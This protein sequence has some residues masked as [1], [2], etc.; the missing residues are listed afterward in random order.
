MLNIL[1]G[2]IIGRFILKI[3]LKL[4]ISTVIATYLNSSLSR[5][6]IKR[7][8]KK[9]D[10][11]MS[12]FPNEK[13]RSFGEFFAR[14]KSSFTFDEEKHHFI[15]PCDGFLSVYKVDSNSSFVIKGIPY[16]VSDLIYDHDLASEYNEGLCLIFRLTPSDYH[17]YCF[18][19][20]CY[21]GPDNFLESMLHSVQPIACERYPVYRQNRRC[22]N[23]LETENFDKIIQ[24]EIGALAVG[25]IVNEK[26]KGNYKKGEIMGHFELC[27]S[28]IAMFVKKDILEIFPEIKEICDN[29]EEY[30]V[31]QG[32]YIASKIN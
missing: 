12:E 24:I 17:Q 26:I 29:E 8:I 15:S 23:V 18:V 31:N 11:D 32:M 9:N 27:G 1:Y 28:S 19:D 30:R 5:F 21:V 7:F 20:N 25:G 16:K 6:R 3:L 13:Y 10:I 4:G 14:R 2:T 22:Y